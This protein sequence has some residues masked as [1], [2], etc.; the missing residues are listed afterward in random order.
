ML[1]SSICSTCSNVSDLN[2]DL[3]NLYKVVRDKPLEFEERMRAHQ[4]MHSKE[5]YYQIRG[6]T[7]L[8]P[9]AA[10][11]RF[12]YLNRTCS[13]GLYRVNKRGEFNV[14]LAPSRPS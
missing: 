6:Q 4:V 7:Y 14:L 11:A 3:I 5:Y 1:S 10:A 9:E 8:E 12:L 13:N 2:A